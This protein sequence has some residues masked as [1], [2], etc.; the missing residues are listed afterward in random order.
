MAEQ[1][2]VRARRCEDL[3][4]D[5]CGPGEEEAEILPIRLQRATAVAGKERDDGQLRLVHLPPNEYPIEVDLI[6]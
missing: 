4:T 2:D 5:R 3:E 6:R 1:L